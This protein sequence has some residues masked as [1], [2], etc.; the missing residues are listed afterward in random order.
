MTKSVYSINQTTYGNIT[1]QGSGSSG[2]YTLATTVNPAYNS[3]SVGSSANPGAVVVKGDAE[4][5]GKVS[6][7]GADLASTLSAIQ[8]RLNILV[9]DPVLLERYESLKQAYEHYK[10]LEA[11]CIDEHTAS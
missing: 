9:P 6:I 1:I 11:L 4:F 10:T 7:N 3:L 5:Y 2:A 8:H